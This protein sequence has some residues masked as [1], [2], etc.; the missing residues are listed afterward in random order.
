[1]K[2]I[3]LNSSGGHSIEVVEAKRWIENFQKK[4]P[5]KPESFFSEKILL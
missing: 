5:E 2:T 3:E 4:H 1:M